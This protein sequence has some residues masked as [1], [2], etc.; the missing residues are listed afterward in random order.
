MHE[1]NTL[2]TS[3]V[4]ATPTVTDTLT[5]A[6]NTV[7]GE[8][9]LYPTPLGLSV[10]PGGVWTANI[11]AAVSSLGAASTVT[12]NAMAVTSYTANITTSGIGTS[13]PA[14][15]AG[16]TPFALCA[17][18]ATA[19]IVASAN[20]TIASFLQT[21]QGLY[22]ITART[23]DL[24]VTITVPG[25]YANENPATS[26]STWTKLFGATTP[27]LTTTLTLQPV[28]MAQPAYTVISGHTDVY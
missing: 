13:R 16:G 8:S 20:P 23:D 17:G 15:A 10:I 7:Q 28:P 11:Y 24:N 26:Y 12:F 4:T 9:Y 22:Q 18:T 19:C 21:P 3:P 2:T 25:T 1:V 6:S 5:P 27:N 14:T